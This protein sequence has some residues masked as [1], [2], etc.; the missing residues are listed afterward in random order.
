MSARSLPLATH[1]LFHTR[2]LDEARAMV[3]HA[4]APHE[5]RLGKH[6]TRFHTRMNGVALDRTGLYSIDYGG[7]VSIAADAWESCFLVMIPLVGAVEVSLGREQVMSTPRL[8]CVESPTECM[9]MRW[10][11]GASH[12][13]AWFDRWALEAHLGGLLGRELHRPLVFSLG[14]DLT[15]PLVRSWLS[16]VDMIRREAET[17]GDLLTRP[18]ALEQLEGLLMTQLLLTQPSNYTPALSGEQPR[19]AP[20]AVNRAMELF[21]ARAGEPLTVVNV[22]EA[23]GVGVRALQEGFRRHLETTPTAYLRDVRLERVRAELTA[24]GP[25]TATIAEVA[26]RWGFVHLGQFSRAYRERFGETPAETLT[27]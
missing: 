8:G 23:V 10:L 12:L 18:L 7:E 25:D 16:I 4:L 17:D 1:E 19:T 15:R 2:D 14:M 9:S 5:L 3:G 24:C 11:T 6:G 20:A 21:E 13:V 22:A 27:R 26:R